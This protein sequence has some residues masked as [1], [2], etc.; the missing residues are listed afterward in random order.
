MLGCINIQ[1][2]YQANISS[3][4]ISQQSVG[5]ESSTKCKV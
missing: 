1:L 2:F 3:T 4:V 5:E